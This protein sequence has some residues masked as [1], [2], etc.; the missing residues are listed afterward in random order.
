MKKIIPVNG[1]HGNF[2]NQDMA[3]TDLDSQD[4]PGMPRLLPLLI[5][6]GFLF[7][8]VMLQAFW[9]VSI[10]VP[11]SLRW[12]AVA[13]CMGMSAAIVLFSLREFSRA[14]TTFHPHQGA[15]ALIRTGTFR[16]SRNPLYVAGSLLISGIGF[17]VDSAWILAMLMLVI[18]TTSVA[19]IAPEERYLERKF[20]EEYLDYRKSVRRWL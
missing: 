16:F 13:L 10:P 1:E 20:G 15:N 6:L 4:N 11:I 19:V 8:G 14:R 2:Q 12:V 5:H 3:S 9:P 17:W 18:P 7:F